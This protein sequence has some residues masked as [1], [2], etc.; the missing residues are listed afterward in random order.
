VLPIAQQVETRLGRSAVFYDDWYEYW[1]AG[2]DSDLLLQRLYG[3]AELVVMCVSGAYGDK[4]W[5]RMEHRAL[6]A[7]LMQAATLEDRHRIFPVRVGDGEVEGVLL[8]EIVPDL[9][10]KTAVEA[11]ELIVARLNLVR[12]GTGDMKPAAARRPGS[13]PVLHRPVARHESQ[14][15]A[16]LAVFISYRRD[17]DAVRAV[18]LDREISGAFNYPGRTPN[19]IV[20]R[21]TSERRGVGWPREVR[22]KCNAANMV[23]V[24]I[25]PNWLE[26]RDRHAL[27]RIDQPDDWVRQ[28]IELALAGNKILI[29]VVFGQ[30]G[31]PARNELPGSIANLAD[32][33]CV[34]ARDELPDELQPVLREIEL[35]LPGSADLNI[36][37]DIGGDHRKLPYPDPPMPIRPS[38]MTEVDINI[39]LNEILKDWEVVSSPLPEDPH[40]LRVELHR[41]FKFRDF[42]DV[43][44]FMAKVADFADKANH[45]PRWENIYE[46]L[47]VYLTTWDIGHRISH[48]DVQLA[49]FFD[50][51]YQ[52]YADQP[53]LAQE[54]H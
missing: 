14:Q 23:L 13:V 45:H 36:R 52:S 27:R 38:P 40:K 51:T 26:A 5:T 39:A 25:G 37:T 30:S 33:P 35:H 42:L 21:D 3:G 19:V 22:D 2:S 20:Y 54:D 41:T 4:A 9:R 8:N 50:R 28:E 11:A 46:T 15:A 47:R 34:I 16:G 12:E 7:R 44:A 49:Q 10:Y 17:M 29:P 48:L 1:I 32:R 18:I 53:Q 6:R 43:L 31:M 24:V